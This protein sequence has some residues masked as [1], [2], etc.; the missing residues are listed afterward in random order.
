MAK[1]FKSKLPA[2]AKE[3]RARS[4]TATSKV[5][6]A[7]A[8]AK[9]DAAAYPGKLSAKAVKNSFAKGKKK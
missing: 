2:S 8:L 6:T 3:S 7:H 4:N 5:G 1:L 9:G